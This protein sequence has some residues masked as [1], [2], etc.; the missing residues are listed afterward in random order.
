[1]DLDFKNEEVIDSVK[2]KPKENTKSDWITLLIL[3]VFMILSLAIGDRSDFYIGLGLLATA[4]IVQY[5]NKKAG[6]IF[7]LVIL[8]TG[9]FSII[10]LFFI[11]ISFSFGL[12]PL[13]NVTFQVIILAVLLFHIFKFNFL[14]SP[15]KRKEERKSASENL[16]NRFKRTFAGRT[17]K[18]LKYLS[19]NKNLSEEARIAA[20]E[21]LGEL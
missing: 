14:K 8:I 17:E 13:F 19:E 6:I 12:Q 1:M 9:T 10:N 18:E 4:S 11:T 16:I 2:L 7:T 20:K 21:L 3:W 5:F 15:K